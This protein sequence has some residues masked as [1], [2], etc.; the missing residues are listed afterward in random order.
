[1]ASS[2]ILRGAPLRITQT[3]KA[4]VIEVLAPCERVLATDAE[5]RGDGS[6]GGLRIG[7]GEHVA[8]A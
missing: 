1:M 8:S 5:P 4:I 2:P 7:A 6:L 3:V